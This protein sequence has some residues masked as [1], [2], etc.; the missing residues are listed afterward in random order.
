MSPNVLVVPVD[1]LL[2]LAS[3]GYALGGRRTG[4]VHHLVAVTVGLFDDAD[5]LV[6]VSGQ[7]LSAGQ[8]VVVPATS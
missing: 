6:Q 7:D 1:A 8:R 2:A 5:G 3:G 4:G